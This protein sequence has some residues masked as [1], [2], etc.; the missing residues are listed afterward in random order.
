ML[1]ATTDEWTAARKILL[2]VQNKAYSILHNIIQQT[3]PLM[4]QSFYDIQ[5][6]I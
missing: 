3:Q 2:N 5:R 6:I 1:W 4:I